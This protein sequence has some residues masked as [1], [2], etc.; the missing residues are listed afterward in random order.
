MR[1]A[2]SGNN[3][4]NPTVT[5]TRADLDKAVADAIAQA[6]KTLG[7]GARTA[8]PAPPK[9]GYS[10]KEAANVS[11]LGRTTIYA[12]VRR[13]ELR[14]VKKGARTIILD[15][16]LRRWIEGLPPPSV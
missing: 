5:L 10:V 12:A 6:L 15:R 3:F 2:P 14:K 4:M 13:G 1:T 8:K 9:I 7:S 11:G 16:D